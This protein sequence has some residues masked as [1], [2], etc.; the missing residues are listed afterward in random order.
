MWLTIEV[1]KLKRK[2]ESSTFQS[3]TFKSSRGQ[4]VNFQVR[5]VYD[6][7][8]AEDGLLDRQLV[9]EDIFKAFNSRVHSVFD[10]FSRRDDQQTPLRIEILTLLESHPSVRENLELD[11]GKYT[12]IS[13]S[14]DDD[15]DEEEGFHRMGSFFV[16]PDA[17]N[18]SEED[19]YYEVDENSKLKDLWLKKRQIN[20]QKGSEASYICGFS[21]GS[22]DVSLISEFDHVKCNH[23]KVS[24]LCLSLK[25]N[26]DHNHSKQCVE[27]GSSRSTTHGSSI[28][29]S[30]ILGMEEMSFISTATGIKGRDG[31]WQENFDSTSRTQI[32]ISE[33]DMS[34]YSIHWD[35]CPLLSKRMN[36]HEN[37]NDAK[38]I[39]SN[40]GEW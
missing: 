27:L 21:L 38:S 13:C 16:R 1:I 5:G 31:F 4:K 39:A 17:E 26:L 12:G 9:R 36:I 23:G 2:Q 11:T 24:M 32:D 28:S 6:L 33:K 20:H 8:D 14:D 15:S 10:R 30:K 18:L 19:Q 37:K 22:N 40:N 29:R 35:P 3:S 34:R 25:D 7:T